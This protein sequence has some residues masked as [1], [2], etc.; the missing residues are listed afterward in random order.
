MAF[1]ICKLSLFKWLALELSHLSTNS[2][3]FGI[4]M[5]NLS[6]FPDMLLLSLTWIV[7]WK[8]G[9]NK[10]IRTFALVGVHCICQYTSDESLSSSENCNDLLIVSLWSLL[11]SGSV[12]T[13]GTANRG[14]EQVLYLYMTDEDGA[15]KTTWFL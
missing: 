11:W 12:E 8:S 1:F 4:K 6:A 5:I 13:V 9:F 3:K 7:N 10:C 15:L 2:F 14:D